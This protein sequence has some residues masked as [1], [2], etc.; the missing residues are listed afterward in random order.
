MRRQGILLYIIDLLIVFSL[1]KSLMHQ[2][3][4]DLSDVIQ[5]FILKKRRGFSPSRASFPQVSL[6]YFVFTAFKA[7]NS[8]N[9]TSF[10]T[11]M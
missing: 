9:T 8:S 3:Q 11:L 6:S 5:P 4:P 7:F 10:K 1:L 2:I